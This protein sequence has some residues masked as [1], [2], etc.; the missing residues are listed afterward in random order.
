[1]TGTKSFTDEVSEMLKA[2]E[3]QYAYAADHVIST[4][5]RTLEQVLEAVLA[6][7]GKPPNG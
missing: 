5:A 7:V 1:L 6:H 2:R 4:E 3:Q